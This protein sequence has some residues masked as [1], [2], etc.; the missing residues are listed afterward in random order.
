MAEPAAQ[1]LVEVKSDSAR[2]MVVGRASYLNC[3]GVA[4]FFDR[5]FEK[6]ICRTFCADFKTCTG[7]DS[8]FLGILAGAALRFRRMTPQGEMTLLNLSERNLELVENL[9]LDKILTVDKSRCKAPFCD[10]S[11][12]PNAPA[13]RGTMLEAHENLVEADASNLEKFEDV[14]SFL[15]REA[16]GSAQ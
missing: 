9:G 5:L 1:F 15:K 11:A 4:D 10:D 12:V 14:I 2:L 6:G 7:M 16:E 8:T 3:K 13:S